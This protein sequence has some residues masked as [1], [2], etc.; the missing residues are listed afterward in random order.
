MI[1]LN[2]IGISYLLFRKDNQLEAMRRLYN[3]REVEIERLQAR[4]KE[5]ERQVKVMDVIKRYSQ[6]LPND[7]QL[8]LAAVILRESKLYD[9]DPLLLLAVIMTESSFIP[10]SISPKGAQGLMQ[11]MP[12]IRDGLYQEVK[13]LEDDEFELTSNSLFDIETNVRLGVYYL[14]KL[15]L[16]Y[17]SMEKGISAYNKG[18]S[19]VD[20]K[21]RLGIAVKK[22]FYRQ[23]LRNYEQLR[24]ECGEI[25]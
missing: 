10:D 9:Y 18:P 17:G 11:L 4:I 6:E 12:H 2:S 21:L 15:I 20:R 3:I 19:R 14:S 7:E 22:G 25:S 1:A 23:V 16:K 24:R 5:L 13:E 8:K